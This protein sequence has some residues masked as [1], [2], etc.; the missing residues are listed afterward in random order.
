MPRVAAEPAPPSQ[1]PPRARVVVVVVFDQLASWVF[2]QYLPHLRHDGALRRGVA[3]GRYFRRAAFEYASTNTASGHAAIVT[4]APPHVT[5]ITANQVWQD[6]EP[7]R[8]FIADGKHP[9]LG[10]PEATASPSVLRVD[11]VGDALERA[12]GDRAQVL[13]LSLKDRAA[14]LMGGHRADLALWYDYHI[15]GF[16][17]STYYGEALP[18]WLLGWL[19]AHPVSELLRPW[20]ALDPAL[21]A[22]VVGR[23][24]GPGEGNYLSLGT[25]FPH[26]LS[27]I[28]KP[29]SA[30]R[31]TPHLT[32]YLLEL[33]QAA[34]EHMDI[35]SDDQPDLVT[36]SISG[37]DYAGHT[38][39]PDSW[40]YLDHLRRADLALGRFL[41]WLERRAPTAVLVT[42]DHG[43]FPLPERAGRGG[44]IFP[45]EILRAMQ[46][47]AVAT[48][49]E[50]RWVLA[51]ERPFA[52][53]AP[54]LTGE[55]R[56]RVVA[57]IKRDLEALPGVEL[58]VGV[59][60]ALGWVSDAD[61][62]RRA[63][64][65]SMA[66]GAPGDLYLVPKEDW[67]V[68][69]DYPRGAGTTH[70]TPW[71]PDREVPVIFWG[72]GVSP[73]RSNEPVSQARVAP[74]IAA[75]LGVA[76]PPHVHQPPLAGAPAALPT[77]R[78]GA[79]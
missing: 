34:I 13:S 47:A 43:V 49:G 64:G 72:P 1:E 48:V 61:P 31:F 59:R 66:A 9:V 77:P 10:R 54:E 17:S 23:D 5:G 73:E 22:R 32:D 4:G 56:E 46:A 55:R 52:Y 41:A 18:E 70:G 27:G 7:E 24:D 16:T 21:Y 50:G 65:L 44:R 33:A 78:G 37:T 57:A 76:P 67:I 53:L 2:S 45:D 30:L 63:V 12:S 11:T 19:R 79:R 71:P 69:E 8:P 38:F 75:L 60:E 39:G 35:G 68:D 58:V 6:G 40:E 42:S 29:Y 15:P 28:D 36:I 20:T 3:Q 14:I 25:T 74:T 26:Q 62:L 51:F